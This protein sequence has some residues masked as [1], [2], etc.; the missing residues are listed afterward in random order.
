MTRASHDWSEIVALAADDDL[1]RMEQLASTLPDVERRVTW[2]EDLAE[3]PWWPLGEDEEPRPCLRLVRCLETSVESILA[4]S[5]ESGWERD[6]FPHI[7]RLELTEAP[8]PR[9]LR[10]S[11]WRMPNARALDLSRVLN[12]AKS[13]FELLAGLPPLAELELKFVGPPDHALGALRQSEA[14]HGLQ[15]LDLTGNWAVGEQIADLAEM[16]LRG[17][18]LAGNR[19]DA[20][21]LERLRG[22][23]LAHAL[24]HLDLRKSASA[25]IDPARLRAW[26][27]SLRSLVLHGDAPTAAN[28]PVISPHTAELAERWTG[29]TPPWTADPS[30]WWSDSET[31]TDPRWATTGLRPL[32]VTTSVD[33]LLRLA[34]PSLLAVERWMVLAEPSTAEQ[35]TRAIA[36]LPRLTEIDLSECVTSNLRKLLERIPSIR[37]LVLRGRMWTRP[38]TDVLLA[39]GAAASLRRFDGSRSHWSTAALAEVGSLALEELELRDCGLDEESLQT[40][41]DQ[42]ILQTLRRLDVRGNKIPLDSWLLQCVPEVLSQW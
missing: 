10:R 7:T 42:P 24:E 9:R 23:A 8:E 30:C 41:R 13:T 33:G 14:A 27:P 36:R 16:P 21:A 4:M 32:A 39:S 3:D 31:H 2:V 29:R 12:S 17:L 37:T 40:F 6:G 22:S 38:A 20:A 1:Y 26:F 19:I 25:E 5:L 34:E 11:L 18:V 35:W 28:Q 15:H